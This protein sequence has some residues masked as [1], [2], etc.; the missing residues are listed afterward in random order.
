VGSALRVEGECPNCGPHQ[1]SSSPKTK[2]FYDV[3][4]D[5]ATATF[6]TGMNIAS[7]HRV[8][9][10]MGLGLPHRSTFY[11]IQ[12]SFV[13]DAVDTAYENQQQELVEE[14]TQREKIDLAGDG[15][16]SAPGYSAKYC[17]YSLMDNV[18][19]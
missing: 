2:K 9:K 18:T 15:R 16:Y 19:K 7:L 4:L 3:N 14:L 11:R 5:L 1:W 12:E 8:G 17:A 13:Y 6:L 10:C